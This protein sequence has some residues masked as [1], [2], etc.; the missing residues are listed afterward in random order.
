M[1]PPLWKDRNVPHSIFG[2][3]NFAKRKLHS[4]NTKEFQRR[5]YTKKVDSWW[6]CCPC[7][8]VYA[9]EFLHCPS[10]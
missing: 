1:D 5:K 9:M 2:S 4:T 3:Y 10:T 7:E 6:N 8:E